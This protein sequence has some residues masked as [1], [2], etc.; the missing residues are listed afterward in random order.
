MSTGETPKSHFITMHCT[1]L[2]MMQTIF[3]QNSKECESQ[4]LFYH[5]LQ[6]LRAACQNTQ[7]ENKQSSAKEV[8]FQKMNAGIVQGGRLFNEKKPQSGKRAVEI[9]VYHELKKY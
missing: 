2:M 7:K 4:I 5:L 9:N 6:N 3:V 1:A 8:V